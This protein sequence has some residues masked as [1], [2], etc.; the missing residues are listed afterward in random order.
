M[1]YFCI[2][3]SESKSIDCEKSFTDLD[4]AKLEW[5]LWPLEAQQ[6]GNGWQA[7]QGDKPFEFPPLVAVPEDT[8]AI[9]TTAEIIEEP[10]DA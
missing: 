7:Y 1:K 2:Y 6:R 4:Q 5:R 9:P 10:V 3:N 8:G